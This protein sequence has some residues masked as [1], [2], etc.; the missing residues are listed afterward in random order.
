MNK[1]SKLLVKR[2]LAERLAKEVEDEKLGKYFAQERPSEVLF[3]ELRF[4]NG[5]RRFYDAKSGSNI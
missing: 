1:T 4:R 2:T 3:R 5:Y